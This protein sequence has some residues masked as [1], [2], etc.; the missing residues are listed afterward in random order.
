MDNLRDFWIG[1]MDCV[2][3]AFQATLWATVLVL[4][5]DLNMFSRPGIY[6]A[7]LHKRQH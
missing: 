5:D 2:C 3:M 7:D 1:L 6:E 4:P